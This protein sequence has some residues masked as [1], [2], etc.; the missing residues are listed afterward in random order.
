[1]M[2]AGQYKAE[3]DRL[4]GVTDNSLLDLAEWAEKEALPWIWR[5][6]AGILGQARLVPLQPHEAIRQGLQTTFA[7]RAK[8]PLNPNFYVAQIT[9][10]DSE[11]MRYCKA[12][13]LFAA[14]AQPYAA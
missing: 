2:D 6:L 8:M 13:K 11:L 5:E 12:V 3:L 7:D 10:L 4:G 14:S 9:M 1:M